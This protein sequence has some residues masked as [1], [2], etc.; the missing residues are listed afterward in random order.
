M[1][2]DP[3]FG[4]ELRRLRQAAGLSLTELASRVHYSKGYLSKVETG[5]ANPN[6]ALAALCDTELGS[7]GTLAALVPV[8]APPEPALSTLP[9]ATAQFVGRT[10][11]LAAIEAA[12]R[13]PVFGGPSVCVVHG[14]AGVGKTAL[15]LRA[16]HRIQGDFAGG[17]LFLDLRGHTPGATPVSAG[18]ALDRFLRLLGV[19]GER[20]PA[21]TDDRAALFR[22]RTRGRALLLVLDNARSAEQVRLLVPAEP[23]CRV[24]V[25]SRH[26]LAALDEASHIALDLPSPDEAAA[27]FRAVCARDEASPEVDSVVERCGR[28]PLAVRIAAA[29]LRSRPSWRVADLNRR[30]ADEP[31][32][33]AALDDGERDVAA[34]FRVSYDDLPAPRRRLLALLTLHPGAD[35][36]H[37]CA[38]ALAGGEVEDALEHLLAGNLLSE[39][40]GRYRMHDLLR[41]FVRTQAETEISDREREAALLRL[42]DAALFSAVR[43]DQFIA[44]Q[45]FR[46]DFAFT[47]KPREPEI[48]DESGAISWLRE[49]WPH[50]VALCLLAGDRG[51]H[52]HCWKLAFTLRSYFFLA[53]LWDPWIRTCERAT[54]SAHADGDAWAEATTLHNLGMAFSDRGDLDDAAA[55]YRRAL[56][57][58]SRLDDQH[59]VHT[60][61]SNLAWV[62]HYRGNH[63][64]ALHGLRT[65]RDFYKRTGS[66]RNAAITTRGLAIV[67]TALADYAGALG[68]ISF[69]LSV[70]DR[71]GLDMDAAMALNTEA[72]IHHLTGHL[73]EAS[74]TYLAARDRSLECGSTYEAARAETGLGNVAH[75]DHRPQDAADHWT[76]AADLHPTLDP[77]MVPEAQTH[78]ATQPPTPTTPTRTS[79]TPT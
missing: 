23:A 54:A 49:E 34:A 20:I 39:L 72:R 30:L 27:L 65:A 16:A 77:A 25:T 32:R 2:G 73:A 10:T 53:K 43:A 75:D 46:P 21:H 58:Y 74:A 3:A 64:A 57:L 12:L 51:F 18:E 6:T 68:D 36:G 17:T 26:H 24:L 4:A 63:D 37:W 78:H 1:A 71:L 8:A 7:G 11:E 48:H 35:L 13:E 40:D 15:A 60:G 45:R 70:F 19:R 69:A 67:K 59:G 31:A 76:R 62:E 61:L 47:E 33:I 22:D 52:S 66:E 41:T 50:L 56:A 38:A 14:M 29:K 5:V 9:P 28:L 79:G 44:P 42:L 55:T